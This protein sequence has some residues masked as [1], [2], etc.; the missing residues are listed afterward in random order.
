MEYYISAICTRPFTFESC[1][2]PLFRLTATQTKYER[3]MEEKKY[4]K[5]KKTKKENKKQ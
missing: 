4:E 1:N 5:R 2:L 3:T